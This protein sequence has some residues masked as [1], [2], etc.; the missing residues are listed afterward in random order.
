MVP[1]MV[2]PDI[3]PVFVMV[4]ELVMDPAFDKVTP[5]GKENVSPLSPRVTVPQ[6]A[7]GVILLFQRKVYPSF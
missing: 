3:V 7:V 4:P 6:F 2:P 5:A 1:V